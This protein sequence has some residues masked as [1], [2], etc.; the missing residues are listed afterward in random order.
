M[1][2]DSHVSAK[3]RTTIINKIKYKIYYL[4]N[5]LY[6]SKSDGQTTVERRSNDSQG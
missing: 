2:I 6:A 5:L 1:I 4:K 3:K